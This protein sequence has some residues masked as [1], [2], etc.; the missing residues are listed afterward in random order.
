VNILQINKF[1]YL[2]GGSERYVFELSELLKEKGHKIIPFSMKDSRNFKS[3]YDRYFI[4]PVK[5][6]KFSIKNIIKLFYNYEAV[7]KLNKLLKNEKIDIAHLHNISHHLSPAIIKVL[8]KNNIPV[9]QTLHD[10]KLICPNYRLFSKNNVC[11]QCKNKRYYY[12]FKK[13]CIKNSYT[14]SFIG[15]LEA[16]FNNKFLKIYDKI[17]LFI[18]PSNYL[19]NVCVDFGIKKE[20]IEVINN[21][22]DLPNQNKEIEKENYFLY[23]GRLSKEKGWEV[24]VEAFKN[25]DRNFKIKIAG[26]GDD[27]KYIKNEID[28]NNLKEKIELVGPKYDEEL[29]KLIASAK[30]I[31][32]PSIWPENFPYS[33]LE[34]IALG[35]IVVCSKIG[36]MPEIIKDGVNGFLFNP[37]D[38]NELT[39]I[40]TKINNLS[41]FEANNIKEMAIKSAALYGK[42]D[43][44]TKILN[45]Y[46][47][48]LLANIK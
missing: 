38:H 12:C 10:Y 27:Y 6:D 9:V 23:F 5:M 39:N 45:V 20:K 33:I 44:Y 1:Y 32:I 2:R 36:G 43:H 21:F 14:K 42:N 15:M 41:T 16:Y 18:S 17:D 48:F 7:K 19:K 40:L 47:R 22:I 26:V 35:K 4:E 30:A 37:G 25:I 11:I 34:S 28:K 46:N 31:V 24:I 29:Y 13:K 8:K 3:E